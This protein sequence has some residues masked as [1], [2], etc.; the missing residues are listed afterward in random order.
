M[1]SGLMPYSLNRGLIGLQHK[2]PPPESSSPHK[3]RFSSQYLSI[4]KGLPSWE[5]KQNPLFH[6]SS[7]YVQE[8][9]VEYI[10]ETKLINTGPRINC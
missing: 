10:A 9:L 4:A 6:S 2:K 1:V 8:A 7:V 5:D 3:L